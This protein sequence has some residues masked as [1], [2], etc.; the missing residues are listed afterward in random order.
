MTHL[1]T[2]GFYDSLH[3]VE[4]QIDLSGWIIGDL[5]SYRI[6]PSHA[7]NEKTVMGK[8]SRRCAFVFRKICRINCL[9]SVQIADSNCVDLN[10]RIRKAVDSE[11]C[12]GRG[13]LREVLGEHSIHLRI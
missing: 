10:Q 2:G 12:S 9:P 7:G 4:C 1:Q 5:A 8:D 3:A 11:Y 13:S 6:N